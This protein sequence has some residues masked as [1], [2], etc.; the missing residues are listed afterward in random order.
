MADSVPT[1]ANAHRVSA[2]ARSGRRWLV[3]L[4]ILIVTGAGIWQCIGRSPRSSDV[5]LPEVS[6]CQPPPVENPGYVGVQACDACH[7]ERVNEFL[8]TRHFRTSRLP[9]ADEMPPGFSGDSAT[10]TTRNPNLQFVM[11]RDGNDFLQ[12]AV[13]TD[14]NG[15]RRTTKKVDLIYGGG[16]VDEIYHVWDRGAFYE[17]PVCWLHPLKQW[18]NS[19]G[20]VDGKANFERK[21]S[22]RCLECHVTWFE[23][24]PGGK[25]EY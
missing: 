24:H 8:T 5:I 25:P 20:Y 2:K 21:T 11:A 15:S 9:R 16:L 22:V 12:T 10:L 23:H 7:Q 17:L 14:A 13:E 4:A 19:P 6:E 18:G 1:S 3:C